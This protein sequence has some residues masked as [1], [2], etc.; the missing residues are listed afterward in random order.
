MV[1]AR[2][3]ALALGLTAGAIS[4]A[5]LLSR[6]AFAGYWEYHI[7][8]ALFTAPPHPG[9]SGAGLFN[10]RGE[11]LGIGS[12][13]VADAL[14]TGQ[15]RLPGNMFVPTD[16]VKPLLGDLSAHGRRRGRRVPDDRRCT[17]AG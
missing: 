17:R 5:R 11:L 2:A 1:A 7:E 14:D 6:R 8:G 16:L 3:L 12:L 9:H 15:P 13:F 10:E 4:A